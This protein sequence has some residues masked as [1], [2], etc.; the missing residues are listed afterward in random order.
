MKK[1][2]SSFIFAF[3]LILPCLFV[4]SACGGDKKL[5]FIE[6]SLADN[7][8]KTNVIEDREFGD[9]TGLDNL[10]IKAKYSDDSEQDIDLADVQVTV[11]YFQNGAQAAV[12]KTFA[13]YKQMCQ[14][15]NLSAGSWTLT[16]SYDGKQC[17]VNVYVSKTNDRN[18]YT[19]K[20]SSKVDTSLAENHIG[21][22]TKFEG[23]N[24]VVSSD[25]N[26]IPDSL[27]E[28]VY[29]LCER[30]Q[31][32]E[33]GYDV[34]SLTQE[35]I[36]QLPTP[37]DLGASQIYEAS[38]FAVLES[39]KPGKYLIFA[40][41]KEQDNYFKTYTNYQTL[42]VEKTKIEAAAEN[43]VLDFT[44]DQSTSESVSFDQILNNSNLKINGKLSI[45]FNSD[46]DNQNN[47][48]SNDDKLTSE[49][50]LEHVF[51]NSQ[52]NYDLSGEHDDRIAIY[53]TLAEVTP[54]SYSFDDADGTET[55][56]LT[57]KVKFVP[58]GDQNWAKALYEESN[59][60]EIK[61]ILRKTNY[62]SQS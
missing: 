31:T 7:Q 16:F 5:N 34:S 55:N 13:Q 26:T 47:D 49:V 19:L 51:E 58:Q 28:N 23:I 54:K 36:A 52:W 45:L 61:I 50:L 17:E 39:V 14:N 62:S 60:F 32:N 12:D 25:N 9:T 41:I 4:L 53:G 2:I 22:G 10:K 57:I 46:F 37:N 11:S 35:E 18:E 24:S 56:I 59:E 44:F 3:C 8:Y 40:E 33:I 30:A 48:L 6:V 1:K 43:L 42:V 15:S 38:T 27:I 21:Y 20:I 29:I